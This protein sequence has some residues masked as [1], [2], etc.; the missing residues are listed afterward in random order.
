[1]FTLFGSFTWFIWFIKPMITL[2]NKR[3]SLRSPGY[4]CLKLILI[5]VKSELIVSDDHWL[6]WWYAMISFPMPIAPES[7][8]PLLSNFTYICKWYKVFKN[9]PSKICGRQPLRNWRDMI[10]LSKPYPFKFSKGYLPQILLGPFLNTFS[11]M[12]KWFIK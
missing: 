8:Q 12:S 1:M 10:C 11:Q 7:F 3:W 6:R 4:V 9:G 2:T 5:D